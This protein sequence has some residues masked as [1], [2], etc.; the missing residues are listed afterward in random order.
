MSR[1]FDY[2]R[3]LGDRWTAELAAFKRWLDGAA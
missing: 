1:L 3:A 2:L